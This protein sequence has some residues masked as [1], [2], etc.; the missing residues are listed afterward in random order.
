MTGK[1]VDCINLGSYNYLGF[2]ENHGTC[3]EASIAAVRDYG[4]GTCSARKEMGNSYK[5]DELDKLVA[6]FVGAEDAITCAMGFATNSM[7]IPAIFNKGCLVL[8]DEKNHAS[9]ILGL[10]LSGATIRVFKHNSKFSNK[11]IVMNKS[12]KSLIFWEK[13]FSSFLHHKIKLY[14]IVHVYIYHKAYVKWFL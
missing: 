2:A 3:A 13:F 9:I 8:S 12:L 1:K 4:I 5:L 7:N 11:E 14:N 10:R 6:R